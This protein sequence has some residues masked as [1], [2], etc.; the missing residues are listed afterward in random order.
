MPH[1]SKYR[2]KPK[3]EKNLVSVFKMVLTKTKNIHE[4]EYFITFLLSETEQLMFAKRIGIAVLIK[5]GLS[6]VD[7][8]DKL[9]VTRET[10]I[11]INLLMQTRG[12]GF[13]IAI[14]QLRK[15]KMLNEFKKFLTALGKYSARAAGGYIKL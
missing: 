3:Q 1:I 15:E 5:E 11:R 4:M 2:L 12:N 10:V 9:G 13:E 6:E 7:I 8:A 14:K